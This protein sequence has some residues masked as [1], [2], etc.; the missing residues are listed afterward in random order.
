[1][2]SDITSLAR[3]IAAATLAAILLAGVL[4]LVAIGMRFSGRRPGRRLG[5]VVVFLFGFQVGGFIVFLEGDPIGR[6]VS[7]AIVGSLWLGFLWQGRRV[8]AG[9][10][11][12]GVAVPWTLVWASYVAMMV[13]GAI[14]AE[15]TITWTLFLAGL[16]PTIIGLALMAVGDPLAPEPAATAR[17]GQ[18]GSRRIGSVAQVVLAPESI[19]P[20]PVSEIAA[21]IATVAGVALVGLIGL[22]FPLEAI[23][24]ITVGTLAG[25][26]ARVLVR[27]TRSRRAFEAFSWLG[28]WEMDRVKA[29]TGRTAPGTRRGAEQLLAAIPATPEYGWIRVEL[30]L[31]LDRLTEARAAADAMPKGTPAERFERAY[32]IDMA[33]WIPGGTGMPEALDAALAGL[34]GEDEDTRLRAEVSMAIRETRMIAAE[35]G[36]DAAIEPLLRVRDRLGARA[37]GQL[38]RGPWRRY[39]PASVIT[40]VVVTL[41]GVP[42]A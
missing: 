1:V 9:A 28:D 2:E 33:D 29:T 8:Q 16:V 24:Q 38:H 25:S 27:P 26:E 3:V 11:L 23:A 5:T 41:L 17:A 30:L 34:A 14:D 42:F 19:G 31:W 7:L 15:P 40:A 36:R 22:P 39:M 4:V 10:L 37:D 20:F 6:A 21:F 18:P 12:T 13:T 32:A 35:Q